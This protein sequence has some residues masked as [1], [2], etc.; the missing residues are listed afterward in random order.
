MHSSKCWIWQYNI[1]WNKATT[2]GTCFVFSVLCFLYFSLLQN[3]AFDFLPVVHVSGFIFIRLFI[4][5]FCF[6]YSFAFIIVF[7]FPQPS[8]HNL[9]YNLKFFVSLTARAN[10]TVNSIFV[11]IFISQFF[12][13]SPHEVF[14]IYLVSNLH[15]YT[16]RQSS[17]L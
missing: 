15:A 13:V 2:W 7:C 6:R 11:I 12:M 14:H 17:L 9:L 10:I 16:Y 8:I 1:S 3:F 5:S 4:C